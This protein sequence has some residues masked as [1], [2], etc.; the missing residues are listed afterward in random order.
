MEQI[1][2]LVCKNCGNGENF[3][4]RY[5]YSCIVDNQGNK[6]EEEE[7]DDEPEYQCPNCGS[8]EVYFDEEDEE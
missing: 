2:K 5:L 7:M 3:I 1:R 6:L 4:A 8:Y